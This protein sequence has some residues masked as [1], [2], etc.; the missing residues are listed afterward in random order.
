MIK[1]L[2]DMVAKVVGK[3]KGNETTAEENNDIFDLQRFLSAQGYE[4]G[5]YNEA[6]QEIKKGY[7]SK[8]WIWYIFPQMDGLGQSAF[9]RLY[10]IKSL[11]EARAYLEN[12][13]LGSRLREASEALLQLEGK[14]IRDVFNGIDAKKV[15]SCM[16]LFDIVSPNDVFDRVLTKY[17]DGKRCPRTTKRFADSIRK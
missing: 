5:G 7:K 11:D 13:V 2:R 3:L 6:L 1:K 10:A 8:H 16:T 14:S 15:K 12:Q 9:S 17:Y 4:N